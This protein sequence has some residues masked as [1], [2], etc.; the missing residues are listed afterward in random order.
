MLRKVSFRCEVRWKEIKNIS[1]DPYCHNLNEKCQPIQ[2]NRL[3]ARLRQ[4]QECFVAKPCAVGNIN[5][6]GKLF[7]GLLQ[8]HCSN[9]N[10][11]NRS[12]T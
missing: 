7:W 3:K 4:Y 12:P 9:V 10:D 6:L 8:S 5:Q 2:N 1:S 11:N